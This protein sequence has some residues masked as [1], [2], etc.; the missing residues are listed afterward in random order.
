MTMRKYLCIA[1]MLLVVAVN[2]H[3][4]HGKRFD[5]EKFKTEMINF[6]VA[7]A[8]LTAAQEQKF[9]PVCEVMLSQKRTLFKRLRETN[10]ATYTTNEE[11]KNA[12]R[13]IDKL[14]LDMKSLEKTYHNQLLRLLPANKV[15]LIMR[16]ESKFHRQA[17]RKA[18]AK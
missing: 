7:E 11:Y 13:T 8:E 18:A 16:A 6:I 1:L 2:S 10:K 4:Q 5:Y 17:F 14:E 15:F 12:I 3:A 9:R